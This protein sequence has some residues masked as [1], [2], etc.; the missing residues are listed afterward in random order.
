MDVPEHV[1]ADGVH[2]QGF[3][4]LDAML[5]IGTWNTGV[6]H[7]CGL[8]YKGLSIEQKGLLSN[9]ECLGGTGCARIP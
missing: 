6:V 3:A 1:D 9:L 4:H 7:L 2:T 8:Y 5:P